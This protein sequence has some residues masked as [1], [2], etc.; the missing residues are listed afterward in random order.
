M[1]N[2]A[3]QI[4]ILLLVAPLPIGLWA[5]GSV[6][7]GWWLGDRQISTPMKT[8]AAGSP[9]FIE[10]AGMVKVAAARMLMGS[11]IS[12]RGD[13]HPAHQVQLDSF[14][15][16]KLTVT[17]DQFAE[18]VQATGYETTAQ[19]RGSSMVFDLDRRAWRNV[20]DATWRSPEGP[21][22]TLVDRGDLPVVHVSWLDATAYAKWAGKR[23]ATE[24][25][26]EL[27]ARGGLMDCEY[28]WGSQLATDPPLANFWQGRFPQQ[29]EGLDGFRGVAPVG[30]FMPN[31]YGLH[32]MTGNVWC[33]CSDWYA[34][35]YYFASPLR[36]PTGPPHGDARVLRGGSWLSTGGAN[37]ELAVAARGH[38]PPHHTAS[39]VG[40]RCA[41]D[42]P[43]THATQLAARPRAPR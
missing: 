27:A 2:R 29:D 5:G 16:D 9:D 42:K 14:W 11:S 36:N 31:R 13:R 10:Q 30:Q 24:A 43:V 39:N 4:V 32:D 26:Y 22:S 41:S 40:F 35:D 7:I 18:F 28:S 34:S 3:W 12:S 23:L 17:N 19:R 21:L 6:A 1:Q 8:V 38:A 15:I 33:W 25:E 20:A 37:S